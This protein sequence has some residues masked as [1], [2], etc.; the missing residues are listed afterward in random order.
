MA[1]A[2]LDGDFTIALWLH[3]PEDRAGVTGDLASCY[4]PS[5]RTGFMLSAVS[6]AGGYNGPGD[7]LRISFGIDDGSEPTWEDCGRPSTA[8]NYISNSLTVFDGALHAATTDAHDPADRGHVYRYEGDQ[9]WQDLGKVADNDAAG[10]GPLV[11]HQGS[12]Y[13]AAWSYDWTRIG[14]GFPSP[15][16]VYRF[17]EPGRWEDCG[18]PGTTPRIFGLASHAGTLWTTGDDFTVHAYRG[19]TTWERVGVWPPDHYARRT[20]L[21]RHTRPVDNVG[22]KPNDLDG[23]R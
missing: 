10:I 23:P 12:L 13:A 2:A 5:R 1:D 8:S 19:G 3:V 21:H 9:S 6:S 4:D 15:C 16:H 20:P 11:V 14:D 17:V 22:A 18:Q 7:E